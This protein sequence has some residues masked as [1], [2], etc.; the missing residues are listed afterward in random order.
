M[1]RFGLSS[2]L[3][4]SSLLRRVLRPYLSRIGSGAIAVSPLPRWVL[5]E[6]RQYLNGLIGSLSKSVDGQW[7]AG[8]QRYVGAVYRRLEVVY[9]RSLLY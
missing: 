8:L 4:P 1:L 3:R 6:E 2:A 7:S 9:D 5:R